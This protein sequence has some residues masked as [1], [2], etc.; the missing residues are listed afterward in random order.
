MGP[1][2][3][4]DYNLTLCSLQSRLQHIYYGKAR[5]DHSHMPESLYPPVRDLSSGEGDCSS[6]KTVMS[7]NAFYIWYM[8]RIGGYRR[9]RQ[10]F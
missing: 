7:V 6:V 5:V 2:A 3:G 9:I 4:A 1:Y 10:E 8:G